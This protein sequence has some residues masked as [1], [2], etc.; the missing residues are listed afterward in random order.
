MLALY[1]LQPIGAKGG[2]LPRNSGTGP[3]LFTFDLNITREFKWKERFKLRPVIEFNNLFNA[4]VFSF[5]SEFIDFAALRSDGT[6]PTA[7][8]NLAR[9]NFLVP[10]RTYRQR[11]IRLGFRFDF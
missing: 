3:S 1:S 5:G 2:N 6:A 7:A 11:E 8:Q 10:T 4:S 9:Q